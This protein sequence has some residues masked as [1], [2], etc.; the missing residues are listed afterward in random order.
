MSFIETISAREAV[1]E[2]RDMYAR[3]QR[4]YGFVPH[5]A[6]V[7]SHRPHVMK[8]WSALQ[9][10]LRREMDKRRF[11]L[12]TVAA[13]TAVRSTYCSLAHGRALLA[14]YS[15]KEVQAIVEDTEESPLTAAEKQMMRFAR[16]VAS[17][18]SAVTEREVADLRSGGFSDA[19][20]FDIAAAATASADAGREEGS[21]SRQRWIAR[22]TAG[23]TPSTRL[24]GVG[25]VDSR[26]RRSISS[27][28]RA[29][30][31]RVPVNS[32]YSTRPSA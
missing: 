15:T 32:S 26:C 28:V 4:H 29:S 1:G 27:G 6:T 7:F 22:S 8:L 2:V 16:K 13:A 14:F 31:T 3:Q 9:S 24:D 10:G 19:E 17:N 5:Y 18:A 25:G 21:V 23:S 20:I 11:E 12:V 30:N